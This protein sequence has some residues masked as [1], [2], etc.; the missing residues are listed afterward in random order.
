MKYL[1]ILVLVLCCFGCKMK[2]S[3]GD[4]SAME[5]TVATNYKC[6]RRCAQKPYCN[7]EM[8]QLCVK[9]CKADNADWYKSLCD[10][11]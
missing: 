5:R 11:P 4:C 7:M 10:R 6:E 1:A 3:I 2:S 8:Y 9:A